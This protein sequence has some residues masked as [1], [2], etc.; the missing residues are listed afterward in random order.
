MDGTPDYFTYNEDP[1]YRRF[2]DQDTAQMDFHQ[3]NLDSFPSD[4]PLALNHL[5]SSLP[6]DS[7]RF[8][9]S[10]VMS[11]EDHIS[12][13]DSQDFSA[14]SHTAP[15]KVESPGLSSGL[16]STP[17]TRAS[18]QLITPYENAPVRMNKG[19][20]EVIE[21]SGHSPP[22]PANGPPSK[23][24]RQQK[25]KAKE[26]CDR[27]EEEA[28]RDKF[29]ER[30]RVAAT[31]CR[32]KKKEWVSELEE[33]KLDLESQNTHL[34]MEYSNL[35]AE[36]SQV[37]AH[38]MAHAGCKDKNIDKWIENEAK[39]YVLG[40][41]ERYDQILSNYGPTPSLD[42]RQGSMSS[43]LGFPN[44]GPNI[45]SPMPPPSQR[46]SVSLSSGLMVPN[47]PILYRPNMAPN[48]NGGSLE[49]T[50]DTFQPGFGHTS[51]VND[52]TDFDGMRM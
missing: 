1:G 39:R 33:A 28:K 52:I 26:G 7:P 42:V 14:T 47:S 20:Q 40:T 27:G 46:G 34:H 5:S 10:P 29:L 32:Q 22:A 17:E 9:R 19:P 13:Y 24:R 41:G 31:K 15:V 36:V 18:Q 45:T 44:A 51:E 37:R 50:S 3:G 25:P 21:A 30:N 11:A 4:G 16:S 23:R 6:M 35:L 49:Q 2:G 12:P 48:S 8:V 43:A 38:I